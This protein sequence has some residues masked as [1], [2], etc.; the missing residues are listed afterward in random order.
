M[1][2]NKMQT[3]IFLKCAHAYFE[4]RTFASSARDNLFMYKFMVCYREWA[5]KRSK[6]LCACNGHFRLAVKVN[7]LH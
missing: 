6:R 2:S 3:D 4:I 1:F 7:H 5:E